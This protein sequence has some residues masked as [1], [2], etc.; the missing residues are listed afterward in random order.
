MT[1]LRRPA[2]Q[3]A[4]ELAPA[5]VLH[6]PVGA[7]TCRHCRHPVRR[8]RDVGWVDT[9]PAFYGGCYDMCTASLSGQH[10]PV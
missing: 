7:T 9:T 2:P 1:T 3:A 4:T 6:H 10:E 8:Y 5:F